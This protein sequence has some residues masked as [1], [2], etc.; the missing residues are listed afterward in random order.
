MFHHR[1]SVKWMDDV[2]LK[3]VTLNYKQENPIFHLKMHV[4]GRGIMCDSVTFEFE[5]V[6][7]QKKSWGYSVVHCNNIYSTFSSAC[8]MILFDL[9]KLED[10]SLM[11]TCNV[12]KASHT[13]L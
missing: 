11:S 4:F 2:T 8:G 13:F 3:N 5:F 6:K 7:G 10:F 1:T 9:L 12:F